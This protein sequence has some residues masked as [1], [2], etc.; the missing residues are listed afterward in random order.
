MNVLINTDEWLVPWLREA[1]TRHIQ[2]QPPAV[3]WSEVESY[4]KQC[5]QEFQRTGLITVDFKQVNT[6][7][8]R[9]L[10]QFRDDVNRS[11][12]NYVSEQRAAVLEQLLQSGLDN[13]T[14]IDRYLQDGQPAFAKAIAPQLSDSLSWIIDSGQADWSQPWF[15]RNIIDNESVLH[16]CMQHNIDFWFVDTGYTNFLH[17]KR[18]VWH[19]LVCNN[20]HYN[21][22]RKKYPSDRLHLLSNFPT[23]WRRKGSAILVVESSAN[24]YLMRGTTLA[25]WRDS[26]E[27]GIRSVSDRPIEF[28]SKSLDRKIRESVYDLLKDNKDYYCVVS[29]SSAAAVESIWTGTPVVTLSTHITNSV[30]RSRLDQINNLY[31]GDLEEWFAML[32]Y[33]QFTFEELCNGTAVDIVREYHCV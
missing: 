14:I 8:F 1:A 26:V 29:D 22:G 31:R 9:D 28:R 16:R 18:K 6:L 15:I 33:N 32:S 11:F 20:I 3:T 5:K 19:R 23:K 13:Q 17:T 4:L 10:Q 7:L 2:Q 21:G 27:Q 12:K 24:H 25:A 30:A